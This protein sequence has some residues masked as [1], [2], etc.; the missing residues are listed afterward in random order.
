[1]PNL[2]LYRTNGSC[3]LAPHALLRHFD[4][5]VSIIRLHKG[6][7][8]RYEAADGSFTNAEYRAVHPLGYVPALRVGD[9]AITEVPA[10]L[11]YISSTVPEEN[12]LGGDALERARVSE[13]L[14][15]LSGTLHGL[16]FVGLWRP[17][18]FSDDEA[19]F[20]AI[21]ARG[22]K[23]IDESFER[24]E[25]RLEGR[26]WA[27]GGGLTVVEFYLYVYARWGKKIGIDV[28]RR[29]PAFGRFA[30]KLETLEGIREAVQDE[31]L[32]FSY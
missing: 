31:G 12:L 2:T 21:R 5:P 10:V 17:Y 3:S 19:A 27:V 9:E 24:I 6:P 13:W 23:V 1:M 16:G 14:N 30:Q 11:N 32:E 7:D 20:E 28:E 18:R 8:G 22:R 29:Y 25:S 15:W 26:E 4:I